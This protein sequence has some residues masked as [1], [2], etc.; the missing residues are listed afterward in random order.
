MTMGTENSNYF[1]VKNFTW[2]KNVLT[3]LVPKNA[4]IYK[5]I[6]IT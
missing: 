6:K 4:A 5:K 1:C 3:Y 2:K